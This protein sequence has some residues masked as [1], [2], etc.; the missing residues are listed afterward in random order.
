L[1][2]GGTTAVNARL[3]INST[4]IAANTNTA[5]ILPLA[6]KANNSVGIAGQISWD[7]NNIYV[8]VGTNSWKKATLSDF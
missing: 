7:S 3:A 1:H 6:T 5:F 8:C 2:A 4:A